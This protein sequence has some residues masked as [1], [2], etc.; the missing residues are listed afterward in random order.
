MKANGIVPQ[1]QKWR[2]CVSVE[3]LSR[4]VVLFSGGFYL[5]HS[6]WKLI[7]S[8]L[9]DSS[10]VDVFSDHFV[11]ILKTNLSIVSVVQFSSSV[12]IHHPVVWIIP[13]Q[14][15]FM[16]SGQELGGSMFWMCHGKRVS[17][18]L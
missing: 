10:T 8:L 2:F 9:M 7:L 12:W 18:M 6:C 11:W 13:L 14:V 5:D 15:L 17:C 4:I 3:V 1:V 16:W